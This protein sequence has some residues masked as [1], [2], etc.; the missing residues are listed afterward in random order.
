M[1]FPI[2]AEVCPT[3]AI[4]VETRQDYRKVF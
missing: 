2:C 3:Q 1:G 4:T